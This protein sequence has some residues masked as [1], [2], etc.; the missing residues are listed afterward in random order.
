MSKTKI[1]L[2][3]DAASATGEELYI[4]K[5]VNDCTCYDKKDLFNSEPDPHCKK[6]FGTGKERLIIKTAKTRFDY[7]TYTQTNSND[8]NITENFDDKT[9]FFLPEI[10]QTINNMDI[11]VVPSNPI[12]FYKIE[13]TLPNIYQNFRFFEVVGKKIP[14]MNVSIGDLNG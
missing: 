3:F 11:I 4:L 8:V 6:C 2:N 14:F 10:Y 5:A 1:H 9:A 12:R 7:T 13:N